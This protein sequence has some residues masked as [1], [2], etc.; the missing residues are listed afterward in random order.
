ME[1]KDS[2]MMIHH[3][4]TPVNS[5]M[6]RKDLHLISNCTILSSVSQ[7]STLL[8]DRMDTLRDITDIRQCV[9]LAKA[10]QPRQI[11]AAQTQGHSHTLPHQRT[12]TNTRSS[13]PML[14][15]STSL[16][17][18]IFTLAFP[19]KTSRPQ[20]SC[21][22]FITSPKD[23]KDIGYFTQIIL[24]HRHS[25]Q[26]HSDQIYYTQTAIQMDVVCGKKRHMY[27]DKQRRPIAITA[28]RNNTFSTQLDVVLHN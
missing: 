28:K 11:S 12:Q 15:S 25:A 1:V 16:S 20:P 22:I 26:C 3:R 23:E 21:F 5:L 19:S 13:S 18:L 4:S 27:R 17:C 14:Q 6:T 7:E 9:Q 8:S 24:T 2:M 10:D